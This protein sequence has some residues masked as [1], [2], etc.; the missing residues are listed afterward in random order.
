MSMCLK[1]SALQT[2]DAERVGTQA[3]L[4]YKFLL[5]TQRLIFDPESLSL[6]KPGVNCQEKIQNNI[7]D[8]I[9]PYI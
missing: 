3:P 1:A 8:D 7:G 6:K 4:T 2:T 9:L 5:C